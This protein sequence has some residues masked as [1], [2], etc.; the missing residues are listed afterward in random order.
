MLKHLNDS[1]KHPS[2][3]VVVGAGGFVGGAVVSKLRKLS[4]PVLPIT[5]KDIDLLSDGA[6]EKLVNLLQPDDVLV[7]AS[8]MAPCKNAE[9]LI[10]NLSIAKVFTDA[11]SLQPVAHVINIGSDAVYADSDKLLDECSC[12]SPDSFHGVMHLAREVM[13][14]NVIKSPLCF[15]RPTLIYGDADPHNGYGP[16]Q[17]RRKAGMGED[18]VLFGEGEE[19]RDHVFIEDVAEIII[20]SI[21]WRSIGILNVVT[22]E[23]RSFRWIA[24]FIASMAQKEIK[25]ISTKRNG[26]MPHNGYRAF[27]NKACRVAFPEF[28]FSSLKEGLKRVG[29]NTTQKN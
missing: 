1:Q 21:I 24:E 10:K 15:L 19:Q 4:I 29:I 13:F 14:R 3:V 27:D 7:A 17:F 23:A 20:Q 16:N 5:R 11:L 25:V 6:L 18:I 26:P 22:G 12:T 2:R 28:Q 8:A 9:M